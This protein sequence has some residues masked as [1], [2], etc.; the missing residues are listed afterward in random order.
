MTNIRERPDHLNSTGIKSYKDLY[1]KGTWKQKETFCLSHGFP[2]IYL[3][4][5]TAK[6]NFKNFRKL[7]RTLNQA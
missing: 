3:P 4:L 7:W 1:F 2:I 6:R 5:P